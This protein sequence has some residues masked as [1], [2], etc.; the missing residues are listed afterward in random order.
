MA[1]SGS[2][3]RH[4]IRVVLVASSVLAIAL[5]ASG[6]A[7]KGF[8]R[9]EMQQME[10]RVGRVEGTANTANSEARGAK[11]LAMQGDQKAQQALMQAELARDIALGNVQREE[12]RTAGVYFAFDS[13]VLNEDAKSAL[14]GVADELRANPNS[15][16]LLAGY[17]DP[18]GDEQYNLQLAERRAAACRLYLAQQLGSDFVRIANIGLGELSSD[19]EGESNKDSRRVDAQIVRPVATSQTGAGSGATD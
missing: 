4:L 14:N 1:M 17:T 12:V 18:I 9:D 8:V 11:D 6:C 7:T 13:S 16:V 15:I 10:E 5:L 2:R 3:V 19:A